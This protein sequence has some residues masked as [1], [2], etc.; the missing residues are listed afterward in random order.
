[1]SAS[2]MTVKREAGPYK[3]YENRGSKV[4]IFV[5]RKMRH[6]KLQRMKVNRETAT[7]L[8]GLPAS[9]FAEYCQQLIEGGKKE[10]S[11]NYYEN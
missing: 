8:A 5:S 6:G 3:L 9:N 4:E 7:L 11:I 10:G 2:N 1:M